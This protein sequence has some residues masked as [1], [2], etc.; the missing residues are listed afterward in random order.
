[1]PVSLWFLFLMLGTMLLRFVPLLVLGRRAGGRRLVD[2]GREQLRDRRA[3][4]SALVIFAVGLLLALYQ[5]SKQRSG[6]PMALSEAVLT[7]LR[8]RLQRQ[9]VVPAAAQRLAYAVGDHH[10]QRPQLCR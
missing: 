1:M 9:G 6:L 2:L 7:Q 3:G 4:T 10:R 5:A 8:D